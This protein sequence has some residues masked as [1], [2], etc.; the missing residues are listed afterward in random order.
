[1]KF[2]RR[3]F[4]HLA[5]GAAALPVAPSISRAQAGWNGLSPAQLSALSSPSDA[6]FQQL[7]PAAALAVFSSQRVSAWQHSDSSVCQA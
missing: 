1:M 3:A 5:A 7:I 6:A 2:P 4:V